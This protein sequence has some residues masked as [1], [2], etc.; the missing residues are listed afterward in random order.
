M[1]NLSQQEKVLFLL[2]LRNGAYCKAHEL[3]QGPDGI[4]VGYE[5][6]ARLTEVAKQYKASGLVDCKRDGKYR[7]CRFATELAYV[8]GQKLPERT[9]KIIARALAQAGNSVPLEKKVIELVYDKE[10]NCMVE[11]VT[12]VPMHLLSL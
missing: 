11:Q 3:M 5:A 2:A 9:Q 7:V 12:C 6:S 1:Q 8:E 4:F 10:R